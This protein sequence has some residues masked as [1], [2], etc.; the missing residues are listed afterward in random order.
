MGRFETHTNGLKLQRTLRG[1]DSRHIPRAVSF[2]G[3]YV[4][5]VLDTYQW[6]GVSLDT[7]QGFFD[8]HQGSMEFHK[9]LRRGGSRHIPMAGSFT[10]H[11][12]G[13][14]RHIPRAGSFTGH[15]VGEVLDTYQCPAVSQDTTWGI[16]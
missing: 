7:M 5:E 12:V 16:F 3:H 6:L 13:V 14:S 15:Y 1:G 11:Y 8:T 9:T 4:G 10:G 2:I